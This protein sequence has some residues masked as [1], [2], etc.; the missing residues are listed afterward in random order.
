[1]VNEEIVGTD[2]DLNWILDAEGDLMTID[3]SDNLA[4]GIYLRLTAY[5]DSMSWCYINYGSYLKDWFGKINEE[6]RRKSLLR[7]VLNKVLLDPRI[8]DAEVEIVDWKPEYIGLKITAYVENK[9]YENYFIFGD[10]PRKNEEVRH[11]DYKNTHIDTRLQGYYAVPGQIVRVHCHVLD[12]DDKRVPIG[13]VSLF[14][15]GYLVKECVNPQEISQSG[16]EEPGSNTFEFRLPKF[17]QT[18]DHELIFKYRGAYKF[19]PSTTTT[20]LHVVDR[21]PT[22]LHFVYPKPQYHYYHANDVDDFTDAVVYIHDYNDSL[23]DHGEVRYYLDE[24]TIENGFILIDYPLV[25]YDDVLITEPVYMK[26]HE[27]I[28]DCSNKFIFK[29]NRMFHTQDIIELVCADGKHVDYLEVYYKRGIYYLTSVDLI[30]GAYF[31][32]DEPH[33]SNCDIIMEVME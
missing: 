33:R 15:G 5:F 7:E 13:E 20:T 19:N 26:V 27:E 24:G 9:S 29:I 3:G 31:K 11:T 23:V 18:G 21:M 30:F 4:Q 32:S 14:I 22:S 17:I 25:F 12:D 28:L 1:M 8:H 6:Y 2:V 16:S 10:L